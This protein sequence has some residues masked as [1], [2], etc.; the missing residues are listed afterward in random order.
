M[1]RWLQSACE[2]TCAARRPERSEKCL[3]VITGLGS[4]VFAVFMGNILSLSLLYG[5]IGPN[6]KKDN[7]YNMECRSS[8][9]TI[10]CVIITRRMCHLVPLLHLGG[11]FLPCSGTVNANLCDN[12]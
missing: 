6:S 2:R 4:V 7:N 5:A 1:G 11:Q 9:I 8:T 12:S 10:K 3:R